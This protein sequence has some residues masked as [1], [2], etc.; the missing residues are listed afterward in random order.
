M[1][2]LKIRSN[3]LKNLQILHFVWVFTI[4]PWS[5]C[6][7]I[8]VMFPW[9]WD[10]Y[11]GVDTVPSYVTGIYGGDNCHVPLVVGTVMVVWTLFLAT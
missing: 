7:V 5:F 4:V 11:G 6:G 8:I 3:Y 1:K 9:W 2:Y 10:N